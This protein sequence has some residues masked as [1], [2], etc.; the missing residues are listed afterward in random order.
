MF[1]AVQSTDVAVVFNRNQ[2]MAALVK[3]GATDVTVDYSG[4]GDSGDVHTI[5][6]LPE[7]LKDALQ[8]EQVLQ[9]HSQWQFLDNEH[10]R[11]E[12]EV[13]ESLESALEHFTYQ[14]LE[15]NHPGWEINDGSSGNVIINVAEDICTLSH[16]MYY[17]ESSLYEHT[18]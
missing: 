9:R 14:W 7:T 3:L 5:T 8:S 2:I 13:L 16:E 1:E 18:L 4:G 6:I 10:K 15:E 12:T 11:V 17:T